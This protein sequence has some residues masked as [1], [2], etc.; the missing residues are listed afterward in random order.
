MTMDNY[1]ENIGCVLEQVDTGN[2]VV[3]YGVFFL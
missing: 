2:Y 1:I 3:D